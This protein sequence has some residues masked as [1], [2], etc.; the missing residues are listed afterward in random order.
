MENKS[1]N[2]ARIWGLTGAIIILMYVVAEIV[3]KSLGL[4]TQDLG[5][6]IQ[7]QNGHW[8]VYT[9]GDWQLLPA[10][11]INLSVGFLFPSIL[12]YFAMRNIAKVTGNYKISSYCGASILT[13]FLPIVPYILIAKSLKWAGQSLANPTLIKAGKIFIIAGFLSLINPSFSF[14]ILEHPAIVVWISDILTI[15][16]LIYFILGF[17]RLHSLTYETA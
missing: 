3:W 11:L 6:G 10:T 17:Y 15:F 4:P 16:G 13:F 1:L 12:I 2:E 8:K 9:F 5:Y 14:K 7:F